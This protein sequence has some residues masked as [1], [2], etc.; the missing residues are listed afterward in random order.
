MKKVYNLDAWIVVNTLVTSIVWVQIRAKACGI[1]RSKVSGFPIVL[2]TRYDHKT[3][4][5]NILGV[6]DQMRHKPACTVTEDG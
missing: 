5:K 3:F 2:S 4:E 6:S 1:C